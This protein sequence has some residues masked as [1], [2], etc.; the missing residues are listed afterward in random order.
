[1]LTIDQLFLGTREAVLRNLFFGVHCLLHAQGIMGYVILRP[2]M[3]AVSV[4]TELAGV[5]GDGE[6][7]YDR[8]YPYGAVVNAAAQFWA[9]YCL[10]LMYQVRFL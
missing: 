3:T 10:V 6:I 9:L 5:Y 4:I 7:R 1:M 8:F 2:V